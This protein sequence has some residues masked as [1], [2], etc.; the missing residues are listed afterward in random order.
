VIKASPD[1][2]KTAF[3]IPN[4]VFCSICRWNEEYGFLLLH[5]EELELLKN[6]EELRDKK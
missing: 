3:E 4:S 6:K 5:Q 1:L 2:F